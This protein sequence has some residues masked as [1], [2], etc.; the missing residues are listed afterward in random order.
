MPK[1]DSAVT[2]EDSSGVPQRALVDSDKHIQVDVLSGGGISGGALEATQQD[3]K[4]AVE[5]LDTKEGATGAASDVD[6][7]RSAQL[8]YIGE[9]LAAIQAAVEA[10][11]DAVSGNELQ[12]DI[13]QMNSVAP[14]MDD[15]DKQAVSLWG[16]G[17]DAGDT[18]LLQNSTRGLFI[19]PYNGK[20]TLADGT[21][22]NQGNFRGSSDQYLMFPVNEFLFNGLTWDRERGNVEGT[23]LASAARTATVQSA[24]QTNYNGRGLI[25]FVNVSSTTATPEI[26]PELQI[27]DSISGQYFT[28]WTAAAALS[29]TGQY[30]Y[31]FVPGGA[32]GS[33]TEAVNIAIGR[34]WRLEMNHVDADSISYSVSC[35]ILM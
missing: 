17:S 32:Q 14:Q 24:D 13:V 27:K 23:L 11:D 21:A 35:S 12:V 16:K 25:L 20:D 30:A 34:S 22:N 31:L 10:L 6:G 8:R 26:T 18:P 7:V 29:A 1:I 15:T 3:V 4:T 2:Y 28:V 33:Y 9:A 5:S 19:L